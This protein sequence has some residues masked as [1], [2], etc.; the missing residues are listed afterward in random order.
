MIERKLHVCKNLAIYLICGEDRLSRKYVTL[1]EA[2]DNNY[3]VLHE[4]GNVGQLSIDNKSGNYVFILSGDIVK[5]GQQ[6]RTVAEDTILQP[7]CNGVPL[8]SF[9]VEQSRWHQRGHE[10]VA[11]FSKSK[12]SL[13][14]RR[15]KIA[16]RATQMQSH[17]W[18]EVKYFQDSVS[19][20]LN[21]DVRSKASRSSLQLTL[22]NEELQKTAKEYLDTLRPAFDENTDVLGF[23]FCING[24]ISTVESFGSAELF[25]KLR[26]KLLESAVNE[27]VFNF[28]KELKF[29]HPA[30]EDV[31]EF[32]VT[33]EQGSVSVKNTGVITVEKCFKTDKSI[34]FRTCHAETGTEEEIHYV[35][36][37]TDDTDVENH[38]N[39]PYNKFRYGGINR[40]RHNI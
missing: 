29:E 9:C 18:N 12:K 19:A 31:I 7:A 14:N 34:L 24:K 35:A 17:V 38:D 10:N 26:D 25:G 32:I 16:A 40:D 36:Y 28:K 8:K 6:D 21:A 2:M 30:A 1:E 33:A 23:A 11:L 15:L 4:T 27:A 39:R 13:S 5:G 3:V 20:N 22:D 37:S